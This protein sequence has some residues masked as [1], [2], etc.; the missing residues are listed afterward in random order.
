MLRIAKHRAF[1]WFFFLVNWSAFGQT[2]PSLVASW[3]FDEGQGTTANDSSGSGNYGVIRGATWATGKIGGALDFS[4]T[5]GYV[6]VSRAISLSSLSLELW[7][8]PH[9]NSGNDSIILNYGNLGFDF[10]IADD[11]TLSAEVGGGNSLV[12]GSFSFYASGNSDRWYHVVYTFDAV[13]RKRQLYRNGAL[14]ASGANSGVFTPN[15]A[16]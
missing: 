1:F 11:G 16:L 2:T 6:A 14:V 4:N 10:R 13:S 5:A 12:D 9:A 7:M 15:A 3:S 8:Y